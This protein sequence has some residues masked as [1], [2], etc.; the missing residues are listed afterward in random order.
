MSEMLVIMCP[1]PDKATATK[2][3]DG[4]VEEQ[5]AA[6]VNILPGIRSV[7]RWQ[8]R[9]CNDAEVLMVIK[10]LLSRFDALETWLLDQHPYDVPEIVALPVSRVSGEYL[11][12]IES[13]VDQPP[14]C[15]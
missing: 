2:L 15:R 3:A 12:W 9:V 14:G 11:A 7:Y 4:L 5:L 13:S 1:C 6:C 8:G 10:S